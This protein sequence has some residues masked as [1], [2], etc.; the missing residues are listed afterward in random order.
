MATYYVKPGGNDGLDGLS[1]ANAWAT[2]SKALTTAAAG[3]FINLDNGTYTQSVELTPTNSGSAGSGYITIQA[4]NSGAATIAMGA[5]QTGSI[6]NFTGKNYWQVQGGIVFQ[7][8]TDYGTDHGLVYANNTDHFRM[9][10]CELTG[11]LSHGIRVKGTATLVQILR[12]KIHAEITPGNDVTLLDGINCNISSTNA[13]VE[14]ANNEIY[15]FNHVGLICHQGGQF[16]VH[17]NQVHDGRAHCLQ[18]GDSGVAT[19]VAVYFYSNDVY[20]AGAWQAQ[21]SPNQAKGFFINY[22]N[23]GDVRMYWNRIWNCGGPALCIQD[24]QQTG[25]ANSIIFAKNTVYNCATDTS[26]SWGLVQ[27]QQDSTYTDPQAVVFR[28]NIFWMV[29]NNQ[30]LIYVY[31]ANGGTALINKLDTDFNFWKGPATYTISVTGATYADLAAWK[32]GKETHATINQDPLFVSTST[33]DYHLQVGSPA[34]DAGTPYAPYTDGYIGAAPDAG[35]YEYGTVAAGIAAAGSAPAVLSFVTAPGP[36]TLYLYN[37]NGSLLQPFYPPTWEM[38]RKVN[39]VGTLVVQVPNTNPT[40]YNNFG[41]DMLATLARNEW[42]R[43][44]S[45]IGN[46]FWF[47]AKKNATRDVITLTFEDAQTLLK[48]RII[49]YYGGD[50]QTDKQQAADD[51]IRVILR[52]NFT[53]SADFGGADTGRNIS[54]YLAVEPDAA[55]GPV[56]AKTL[57]WKPVYNAVQEIVKAAEDLGTYLAFDFIPLV[58][59]GGGTFQLRAQVFT[60]QRGVDHRQGSAQPVYLGPDFRNLDSWEIEDDWTAEENHLYLGG[61]GDDM[62]RLILET[63]K[64][65]VVNASPLGRKEGW[66]DFRELDVSTDLLNAGNTALAASVTRARLKGRFV[67]N[68]TTKWGTHLNFGDFVTAQVNGMSFEARLNTEHRTFNPDNGDQL[69]VRIEGT[70]VAS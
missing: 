31:D 40:L 1:L 23:L 62:Y 61:E 56:I 34:I 35:A 18:A 41:R 51:M 17:D 10:D 47:L 13:N 66:R 63:E 29:G 26:L 38:V 48:R 30:K 32:S 16:L 9:T 21:F 7:G 50:I 6:F 28:D 22:K 45:L 20:G 43:Q 4:I 59:P 70:L 11:F 49:A 52:E 27:L 46:T 33:P 14:I 53:T 39:E 15:H 19:D 69:D 24:T 2:V 68:S 44:E 58:L 42:G 3:D 55:T 54:T 64:T 67:E 36:Y 65:S 8:R 25:H 5:A 60:Q 57:E 37:P 12:N